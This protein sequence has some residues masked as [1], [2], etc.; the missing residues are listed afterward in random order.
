MIY[1]K[2]FSKNG[3]KHFVIG[4][5]CGD[6]LEKCAYSVRKNI[7]ELIYDYLVGIEVSFSGYKNRGNHLLLIRRVS[8]ILFNLFIN[9]VLDRC[10]S[11][12]TGIFSYR[13]LSR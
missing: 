2:R 1:V 9:F 4:K 7:T 5:K 13:M 3:L 12:V 10:N 6:V 11:F 8:F